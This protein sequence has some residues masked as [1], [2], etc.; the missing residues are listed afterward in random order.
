MA[1]KKP[2]KWDLETEVLVLG[3]GCAGLPAAILAHD[4]G[5]KVMVLERTAK[6]GGTTAVSGGGV[7]VPNNHLMKEKGIKDSK[8]AA[9][10]YCKRLSG[11]KSSDELIE[12]Y[13][14]VVPEMI[15]YM[16]DNTPIKF[17]ITEL[18][19]YHPE[20]E[21]AHQGNESRTLGPL[22]YDTNELGDAKENLRV[23]PTMSMPMTF[24][25]SR[26][27]KPTCT[28]E[29]VPWEKMGERLANGIT[30]WGG[31]VTAPLY[32]ACLDRKIEIV[33]NTRAID[34]VMEDGKVIGVVAQQDGKDICVGASKGV[35]LACG[36]FEWNEELKT[37]F[38]PG[39]ITHPCSP[40][41]NEGDAL[42]MGMSA[43]AALGNMSEQWGWISAIIPGE[44]SEG[45]QL[46]RG[47]IYERSMPHCII[48]NPK[49]KRF[50]NESAAYNDMF[51]PFWEVDE[52]TLKF[53][54]LPAWAIFD[55][56]YKDKY[57]FLTAMPGEDVPEW[58][59][60]ADSLEELAEKINIDAAGLKETVEKF[61]GYVKDN[62]DPDFARGDSE[63]DLYWG[64]DRNEPCACLG[65]LEK[66]VFYAC[67][68]LLG[69]LG[70][71]GGPKTTLDGQVIDAHGK[72]ITGLYAAGN[73]MAS[74]AGGSYFGGGATIG[75]GMVFGYLAGIHAAKQ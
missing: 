44:E 9:M 32:K 22:L 11:G 25:E 45:I 66:P 2:G 72:P 29:K 56:Q 53:K 12:K 51:K 27:W 26:Q 37:D 23:S 34:V 20:F 46:N 40:P 67:E 10:T 71:K 42:K 48:V 50:V 18:S 47:I 36:G 31:G 39:P 57:P 13:L 49:G 54:N 5:A 55:Q 4:N 74:V 24:S 16:V 17:E 15:Q 8:E 43:G 69:S 52:N 59:V 33:L 73:A 63:Y 14:D 68:M 58:L 1:I 38:L 19:D 3:T 65:T 41:I 35:I 6:V 30:C 75:S 61:N 60:Q 70:T 62:K 7:W 64:D 21:G 28:P